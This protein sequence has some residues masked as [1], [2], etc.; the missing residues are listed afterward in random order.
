MKKISSNQKTLQNK[1]KDAD[2]RSSAG[3]DGA[4]IASNLTGLPNALKSGIEALSGFSLDD[5]KVH[6]NS[7]KPAA[8]QA[9]AYAQGQDIHLGPGQERHLPHEAWHVVQQKQGRVKEN[10]HMKGLPI[11]D[12]AALEAEASE[13]GIK[14]LQTP[15]ADSKGIIQNKATPN[16][17]I[18]QRITADEP[19]QEYIAMD[20][21]GYRALAD[22]ESI[23]TDSMSTC[24]TIAIYNDAHQAL[25]AHFG[26]GSLLVDPIDDV[27]AGAIEI[28]QTIE[29]LGGDWHGWVFTGM[30]EPHKISQLRIKILK[31]KFGFLKDAGGHAGVTL[32]RSGDTITPSW[33]AASQAVNALDLAT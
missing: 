13:M 30:K 22:G 20:H 25:I 10:R 4:A 19:G 26:S 9:L 5:V 23:G 29:E 6:T 12:D 28:A 2:T 8:L 24:V 14:A 17:Q 21:W 18:V 1:R 31:K 27:K 3:P 16:A 32:T 7:S 15:A 33:I 11:N